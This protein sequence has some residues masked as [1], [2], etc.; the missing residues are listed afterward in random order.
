MS[1]C[2]TGISVSILTLPVVLVYGA[3]NRVGTMAL[4]QMSAL[5][6]VS[7]MILALWHKQLMLALILYWQWCQ[8]YG[9]GNGVRVM[10][11]ATELAFFH[12][13]QYRWYSTTNGVDMMAPAITSMLWHQSYNFAIMVLHWQECWDGY[14][15]YGVIINHC[16]SHEHSSV[17]MNQ[18]EFKGLLHSHHIDHISTA[19]SNQLC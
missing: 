4:A 10:I 8:H 5:H 18:W 16:Q 15:Y 6:Q 1:V 14:Q 13:Q 7:T 3:S 9:S 17:I 2:G 19:G 12:Q 11:L